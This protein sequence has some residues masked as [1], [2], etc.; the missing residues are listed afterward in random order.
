MIMTSEITAFENAYNS[1]LKKSTEQ[2]YLLFEDVLSCCSSFS[3]DIQDTDRL[4]SLILENGIILYEIKPKTKENTLDL[5]D[6][7]DWAHTDYEPV[8]S[9]IIELDS[10]QK[11][12]V[13]YV[14]NI[15][16][17]QKREIN[18]LQYQL[19]E[20]NEYARKRII[21]M[22]LRLA[23]KLALQYSQRYGQEIGDMISFACEGLC[24]ASDS[25]KPDENGKFSG[26]ASFWIMQVF[27][28]NITTMRPTIY[29][30]AHF[31]EKYFKIYKNLA[32]LEISKGDDF[33]SQ[34]NIAK[35]K[36]FL[37]CT[38][39]QAKEVALAFIPFDNLE[40]YITGDSSETESGIVE[41]DFQS[42]GMMMKNQNPAESILRYSVQHQISAVLNNLKPQYKKVMIMRYGLNFMLKNGD[43][44]FERV[45]HKLKDK[46]SSNKFSKAENKSE[47]IAAEKEILGKTDYLY[48][49]TV[50]GE[51]IS[52]EEIGSLLSL[53]RERIRQ[54]QSKAEKTLRTLLKF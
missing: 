23:L 11:M 40:S 8:Y 34:K 51:E 32:Y 33:L 54:I 49:K 48:A 10:S 20:G 44:I 37:E 42:R 16:P 15:I 18:V 46:Q 53:T 17:P 26:Y 22:H 36:E 50:S 2:G 6:F 7:Y 9:R 27:M 39:E 43:I 4:T 38:P 25:W 35:I 12:F 13:D 30:P 5:D 47:F 41:V 52:L 19:I 3:L 45:N 21:E 24:K 28:R 31:M 29:Y 14:R 1:L